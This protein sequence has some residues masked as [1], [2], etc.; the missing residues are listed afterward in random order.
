MDTQSNSFKIFMDTS[1][2]NLKNL[3]M[4]FNDLILS[5][6]DDSESLKLTVD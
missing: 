6:K 1:N 3:K 5:V 2:K 4:D